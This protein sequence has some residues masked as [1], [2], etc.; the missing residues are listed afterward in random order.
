MLAYIHHNPIHHNFTS[1][2]EE[3]RYSS[4]FTFISDHTSFI[5][6]EKLLIL[7]ND[8]IDKAKELYA[9]FHEDFK[10]NNF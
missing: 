1:T 7:F 9:E 2:Y 5:N 4:Y 6:R 10:I 8:D 3:W